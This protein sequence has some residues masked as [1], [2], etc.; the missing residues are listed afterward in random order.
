M[1]GLL[2]AAAIALILL[3]AGQSFAQAADKPNADKDVAGSKDHPLLK[4]FEGSIILRY[5]QKNFDEFVIPAERV[6]FDY[7]AQKF[8]DWKRL[9][10]E[11]IRTTGFYRMP[12]DASTLEA[13]KN[14][15]ND[16]K[17]K[18]FEV[19]FSG[20]KE[21]LDNGYGR[22]VNQVYTSEADYDRQK[23]TMASADDYRYIAMKKAR[24]EGDIYVTVFAAATPSSWKDNILAAGQVL[25]RVDVIETKPI[26]DRMVKIT[27]AEM[28][29]A[30]GAAG[31]VALYGIYF[32]FNK[33]DVKPESDA[34]LQ[35]MAKLLKDSPAMRAVIVG[36]TDA[37]GGFEFNRDL[38]AKR[39]AAVIDA[40]A[41][42]FGI[43]RERLLPFGASFAAPVATNETEEG[44]AKNRRVEL[45]NYQESYDDTRTRGKR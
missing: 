36:H 15:E 2:S 42:R 39:A 43:A 38:S 9:K 6:V 27:A 10:V 34:T 1:K 26:D 29:Q 41:A 8:N 33:A 28:A 44:R 17:P 31:K 22:F 11:G 45:V 7:G 24:P 30:L 14:Y 23:Y 37:V 18:G 3:T 20:S 4:R 25:A 40:L 19:L 13:I 5:K 32:D 12:P 21:E 35:E 16:L